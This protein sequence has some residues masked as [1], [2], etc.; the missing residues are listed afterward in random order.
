[1]ATATWIQRFAA[2]PPPD[3]IN[4]ALT[5]EEASVLL[6]VANVILGPNSGPRGKMNDVFWALRDAGV[7]KADIYMA[8][9]LRLEAK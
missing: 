1:M 6:S 5:A 8:G 2:E 4:L 3:V 7:V 9:G